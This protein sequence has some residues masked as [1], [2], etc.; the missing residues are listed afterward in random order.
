MKK[1]L[2]ITVVSLSLAMIQEPSKAGASCTGTKFCGNNQWVEC[3]LTI[4]PFG[5]CLIQDLPN[6]VRCIA[7]DEERTVVDTKTT[8]CSGSG[9][10]G[11]GNN[12]PICDP[13][14]P[15]YWVYCDPF[16]L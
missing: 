11:S 5:D 14:D 3:E 15:L 12:G 8:Y 1:I 13:S 9:G 7:R 4:P 6:G 16:A 2:L 10:S